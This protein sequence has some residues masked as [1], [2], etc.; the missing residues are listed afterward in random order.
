[1]VQKYGIKAIDDPASF[2]EK[3]AKDK[4]LSQE[5][6]KAALDELVQS[7][8][9]GNLFGVSQAISAAAH[10]FDGEQSYELQRVSTDVLALPVGS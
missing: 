7:P 9:A 5:L 2:M 6:F 10:R 4:E 8:D 1:M 3:V